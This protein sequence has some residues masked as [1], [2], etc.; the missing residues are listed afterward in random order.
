MAKE[1]QLKTRVPHV[2]E[3]PG[4]AAIAKVYAQSFLDA[5]TAAGIK[6]PLVE[7]SSFVTE[8]LEKN[9]E[10]DQL[11]TAS[12]LTSAQRVELIDRIVAPHS[13]ELFA[14]FLRVLA[15][16]DRLM[17]LLSIL[18]FGEM[19]QES[20]DGKRRVQIT[21]AQDLNSKTRDTIEQK[22]SKALSFIPVLETR[23]DPRLIGG[24]VI[25][26]GDTV[27]DGSLRTRLNKLRDSL[28][29][30]SLHEIQSGRDRF[31]HPE[32]D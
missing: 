28:R 30:R 3:D 21:T 26:I 11:L 6:E 18:H 10:F 14:S 4:S 25:Q 27:Y 16:H 22:L 9:P 7:F 29:K 8:V 31:S 13:S 19:E 32:G 23:S 5:A 17:L 15:R 20:R 12:T 2:L 24:M 1:Q